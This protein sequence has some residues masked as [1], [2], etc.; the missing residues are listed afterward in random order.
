MLVIHLKFQVTKLEY[1]YIY[2][3]F[4]CMRIF[5]EKFLDFQKDITDSTGKLNFNLPSS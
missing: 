3:Y 5:K 4:N 2:L 1:I